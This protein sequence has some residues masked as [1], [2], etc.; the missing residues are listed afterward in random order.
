VRSFGFNADGGADA[1]LG[2]ERTTIFIMRKTQRS[3]GSKSHPQDEQ[4]IGGF[5]IGSWISEAE[6][7][8]IHGQRSRLGAE[9][10]PSTRLFKNEADISLA[11]RSF[12]S[13]VLT[14][15][16]KTGPLKDALDQG[17]RVV[18]LTDFPNSGISLLDFISAA[19]SGGVISAT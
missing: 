12:H 18:F 4:R 6:T 1:R 16:K 2:F 3:Y 9:K 10:K 13:I 11:A 15:D 7:A 17:G 8:F 14:L 19:L 5:N